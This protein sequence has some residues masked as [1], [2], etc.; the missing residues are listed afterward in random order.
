MVRPQ[1][2]LGLSV[3]E[4]RRWYWLKSELLVFC[5]TEGLTCAGPKPDLA[6]RIDA[7]LRGAAQPSVNRVSRKGVMPRYFTEQTVIG[8]GWRCGPSL[9]QFFR[10]NCGKNFRF[11][12]AIRNFIHTQAGPTLAEAIACYKASLL[13][14]KLRVRWPISLTDLKQ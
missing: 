8:E 3:E 6:A 9:G 1:L 5:Q 2:K 11:N 13:V 10:G 4:F 7:Y 14:I 12:A